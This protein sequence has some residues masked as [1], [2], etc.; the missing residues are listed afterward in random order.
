MRLR[1]TKLSGALMRL[2]ANRGTSFFAA[3]ICCGVFLFALS[4]CDS[5]SLPS[6]DEVKS[7]L[8]STVDLFQYIPNQEFA[9]L[10]FTDVN[11]IIE[12]PWAQEL[13]D[14]YPA[15]RVWDTKL[16]V[17]IDSFEQFA[18]AIDFE[19]IDD[20]QVLIILKSTLTEKEIL[21]LIG[22]RRR[23]FDEDNVG[24]RVLFTSGEDFS[25]G[26][27]NDRIVALG[28]TSLVKQSLEVANGERIALTE[29]EFIK[30]FEPYFTKNDDFWLGINNIKKYIEF[31]NQPV[32]MP[33]GLKTIDFVYFGIS[34]R[35]GISS[36]FIGEA[37]DADSAG[38]IARSLNM[39]KGITRKLSEGIIDFKDEAEYSGLTSEELKTMFGDFIDNVNIS[40]Q[41]N[42]VVI[43]FVFPDELLDFFLELSKNALS[44][45]ELKGEFSDGIG[46]FR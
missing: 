17:G 46:D 37:P 3:I 45:T 1:Y 40:N 26:V 33:H 38:K 36:Q 19:N 42:Q 27:I 29:G 14:L 15:L 5:I 8:E 16:G 21:S 9:S 20:P 39:V 25:F 6:P 31:T 44:D 41:S 24:E 32:M 7:R 30:P 10:G 22:E 28:S 34:A 11:S 12:N 4:G 13:F 35:N 2:F 18:M 23:Y 43:R